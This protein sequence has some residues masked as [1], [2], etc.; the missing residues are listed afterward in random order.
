MPCHSCDPF[1]TTVE[2]K[3]P[4]QLARLIGKIRAAV[5]AQTL[6]Y[7]SF[8]SDRELIG[9]PSFSD[10]SSIGPWPDVMRYHF[11]CCSCR[12]SYLLIAETYHG[13][14]GTWQPITLPPSNPSF[15][16]TS[17]GCG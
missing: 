7:E 3:S 12:A 8:E 2:L 16:P 1:D 14:G 9:Q 17:F 6:H 11:S 4:A 10:V 15:Q 13:A 5:N